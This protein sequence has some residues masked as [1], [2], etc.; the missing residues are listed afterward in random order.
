MQNT[1]NNVLYCNDLLDI[2]S[3]RQIFGPAQN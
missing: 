2:T 1:A 3:F